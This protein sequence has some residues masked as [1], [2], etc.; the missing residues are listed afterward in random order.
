LQMQFLAMS[1]SMKH[2]LKALQQISN[3]TYQKAL[4]AHQKAKALEADLLRQIRL[5]KQTEKHLQHLSKEALFQFADGVYHWIKHNNATKELYH[6]NLASC[7]LDLRQTQRG[8]RKALAQKDYIK[9][10]V[11]RDHSEEKALRDAAK[12]ALQHQLHY[13]KTSPFH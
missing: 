8:L 13:L 5:N 2:N 4:R 7:A 10:K 3:L 12:M 1:K 11:L 9:Q 6:Q